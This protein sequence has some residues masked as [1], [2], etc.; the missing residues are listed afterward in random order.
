M[1]RRKL[2]AS[3][4]AF[5]APA[6]AAPTSKDQRFP[7]WPVYDASEEQAVASVV[8]SGKWSRGNG[9]A[10]AAFE[11]SF[12]E[13]M[14]AKA[15]LATSG[16]TT[17]LLTTLGAMEIQAGDEVILT[18]YTFI[19]CVNAILMMNALPVFADVD[20]ETF[21]I[22]PKTISK[23]V[24]DRTVAVMPVHIGGSTFD[25]DAVRAVAAQHKLRIIEDSCQSHLAEWRGQRTGSFGVA[26]CFSFQASKNLNS[27]EGGAILSSDEE[28]IERCYE[29]HNNSGGRRRTGGMSGY[30]RR[31]ANFR[32]SEFQGAMLTSQ[33]QRLESQS[34]VREKNAQYLTSM[35]REIPGIRP[36]RMY[37]GTTRNAYHLYMFR[38]D[39]DAFGRKARSEFLQALRSEGIPCSGGYSPLNREPFLENT[40][41]SRGFQRLFSKERLARWREQNQCPQNDRLCQEGVWFTQ[42]MLLAPRSD[43][44][45]IAEAITGFRK[46]VA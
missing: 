35:L 32:L 7:S 29:F 46:K 27:G 17:A 34:R 43:M 11:R 19:A 6:A 26:G 36:A 9:S 14:G 1:T 42:N 21:Q 30:Q 20:R 39:S 45:R 12:A 18:P 13:L 22:D 5:A 24:T 40:F 16:G 28:F 31:G 44:E 10:V 33:M 41:A 4:A 37:E 25:V 23:L 8:R 15:C 3:S 38:Y 2:I